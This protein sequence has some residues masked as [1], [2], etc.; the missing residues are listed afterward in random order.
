LIVDMMC[1]LQECY[2]KYAIPMIESDQR[3]LDALDYVPG[4]QREEDDKPEYH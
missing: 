4:H 3:R 1:N 2:E